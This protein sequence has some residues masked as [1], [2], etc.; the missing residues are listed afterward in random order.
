MTTAGPEISTE[1][2]QGVH[3]NSVYRSVLLENELASFDS[4]LSITPEKMIKKVRD[5]RQTARVSLLRQG[6]RTA[7]YLKLS[8][9]SWLTNFLKTIRKFTRQRGSLVHEYLNLVRLRQ[10]GIPSITPIAAGTRVRGLRC[11]SFLL[12]DDLGP[13]R[14]L[15]DFVPEEFTEPFSQEQAKRKKTLVRALA[16]LTREMHGGGIN[17]RDYYLCHIHILPDEQPWPKLFVIDL[18]R[19]D[20]RK[21]VGK[22]WIIKDLAALNYSAPSSVFS[23]ADRLRFLKLYLGTDRLGN[24]HRGLAGKILKKTAGIARHALRSKAKDIAYMAGTSAL[25][26]GCSEEDSS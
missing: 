10:L 5:D 17:H 15:E 4:F 20:R 23:R 16:S 14:K 7:G 22:R 19:A 13:T 21:R 6:K 26:R 12:T 25:S 3:I 2:N 24:T 11:E 18:N 8:I 1:I 9:Y